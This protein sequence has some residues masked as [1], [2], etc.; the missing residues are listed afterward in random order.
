VARAGEAFGRR[1]LEAWEPSLAA[2][3]AAILAV[4]A[5]PVPGP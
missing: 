5:T 3:V 2:D 1:L 4:S